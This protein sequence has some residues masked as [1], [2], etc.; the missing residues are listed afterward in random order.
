MTRPIYV[1]IDG[2]LTLDP[3][4]AW[5]RPHAGR[6]SRLRRLIREGQEVV[7]WSARGRDYAR[8]FSAHYGIPATFCMSKPD[9]IIDDVPTIRPGLAVEPPDAL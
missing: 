7:L 1:D 4:R 8:S 3:G 6:I 2:T 9:R 5:G